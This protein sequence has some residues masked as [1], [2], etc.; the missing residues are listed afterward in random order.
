[1]VIFLGIIGDIFSDHLSQF[2]MQLDGPFSSMI[3]NH[4]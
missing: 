4:L 3:W 2:P 1:M